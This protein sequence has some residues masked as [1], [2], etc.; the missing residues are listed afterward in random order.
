MA[1]RKKKDETDTV[2]LSGEIVDKIVDILQEELQIEH[3]GIEEK[4]TL[5]RIVSLSVGLYMMELRE[6]INRTSR[7]T[8]WKLNGLNHK[9]L[10]F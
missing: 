9:Y 4:N 6:A 2:E 7:L 5:E 8:Q 3:L 10:L 1:K